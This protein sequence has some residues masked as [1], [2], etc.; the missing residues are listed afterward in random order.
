MP[1]IFTH[2]Q[3]GKEVAKTLPKELRELIERHLPTF[4]L[5]TQGP[6]ILFYHKP[7]RSKKKNP[8]RKL[9]WDM[10]AET[11]AP[12][13]EKVAKILDDHPTEGQ[14]AYAVGFL[15]HFTL[16]KTCH[17]FIDEHA[18]NG[19]SHG[20]IEAELD[21]RYFQKAGYPK[22][23]VN[24]AKL[25][26]PFEEAKQ[27]S[28][29]LLGVPEKNMQIAVRS[30]KKINRLFSH[31][32]GLVH[33]FCHSVLTV[34]GMN[35]IFGE[36]FLYKKEDARCAPLLPTIVSLFEGAIPVA[37][38]KI[39]EYFNQIPTIAQTGLTDTFYHYNYSGIKE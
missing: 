33:G 38:E 32:C 6:D 18:V 15:C 31:K 30:M 29:S 26:F 36:M 27:A 12:F 11:G 39:I 28:A 35:K 20:K 19:L 21:K 1:A 7:L 9:G 25:F 13:F 8:I 22:R 14:I 17:P 2:I 37:R 23:G 16:D 4:Y 24:A 10:H 5:G 3:F 34:A